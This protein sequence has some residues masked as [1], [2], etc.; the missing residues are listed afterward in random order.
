MSSMLL[1]EDGRVLHRSNLGYCGM[2]QLI[3]N[4]VSDSHFKLRTW[5][6]DMAKRTPPFCEFDLRGLTDGDRQEFWAASDLALLKLVARRGPESAWPDNMYAGESLSH[7][8][9]MH[10]SIL[11]GDPPSRLND[12]HE[13]I[14]FSGIFEDLDELWSID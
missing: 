13:T 11:A 14:D 10:R 3:A 1:L 8:M 5:L 6:A 2:L 12:L 7:L 4:E 9:K